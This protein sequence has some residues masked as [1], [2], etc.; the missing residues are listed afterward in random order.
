MSKQRLISFGCSYAF[1]H[2]LPDC[3][4]KNNIDPGVYPSKLAYTNLLA[5]RLGLEHINLSRPGASNKEISYRAKT[6]EYLSSDIVLLSWTNS[7]RTS[8]LNKDNIHIIGPWCPDKTSKL[9]YKFFYNEIEEAFMTEVLVTWTNL[10]LSKKQ[11]L[12]FNC[13]PILNHSQQKV[14]LDN[15]NLIMFDK[16]IV[17]LRED[18][19]LDNSHPGVKTHRVY[20]DYILE[21]YMKDL[22]K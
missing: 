18:R 13:P 8:V 16:H 1:G 2:G 17:N 10:F 6:F 14:E 7:E 3:V 21:K 22:L 12:V 4:G 11:L 20:C 9:Y 19:A 15:Y 5:E